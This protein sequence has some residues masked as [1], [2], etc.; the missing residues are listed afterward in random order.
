V[1]GGFVVLGSR[2]PR[3]AD[4]D[5]AKTWPEHR[6]HRGPRGLQLRAGQPQL[7]Q[8][9]GETEAPRRA[10]RRGYTCAR[11]SPRLWRR[12]RWPWREPPRTT[13]ACAAT[14]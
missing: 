11:S 5:D 3:R 6:V 2:G 8:A 7:L 12:T 14:L 10:R 13:R 4:A 1:R 9:R